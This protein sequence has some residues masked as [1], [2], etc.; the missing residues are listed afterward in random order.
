MRDTTRPLGIEGAWVIQPEIHPDR[1]G[2]FHAWFQSSEFRRLTGHSFSVPQ[3]NIAVSRKGA[4]RGIHF[5]EVPPGQAKYSACVQGAGVEVVVDIRLGSPTYGQWRAVP[6]DEYNRTAVYVP[7]GLGRAF[8]ALTDR[9][10]LV[11]LCSSEYAA[12]REHAVN[13][14][15]PD[16]AIAWPEDVELLLSERDTR[17][18]TLA[19]AARRGILPSYQEYREHH[20]LP[21]E[22]A[23]R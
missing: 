6:V 7:A 20:G 15:D 10:T 2:E 9:T 3:V 17:A 18:P 19:E 5:S 12:R 4:L 14:L 8:V 1:R 23:R 11:Y 13:P 21:P 22:H 16:L